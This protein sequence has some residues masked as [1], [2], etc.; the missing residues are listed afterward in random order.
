M[1]GLHGDAGRVEAQE[2]WQRYSSHCNE[3]LILHRSTGISAENP[4][5]EDVSAQR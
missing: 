5:A 2:P 4:S 1:D 3:D